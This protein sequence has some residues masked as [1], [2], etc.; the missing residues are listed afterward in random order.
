[1]TRDKRLFAR[2]LVHQKIIST[3]VTSA[4]SQPCYRFVHESR[5]WHALLSEGLS[6]T[7]WVIISPTYLSR[8]TEA[9]QKDFLFKL[10]ASKGCYG[11]S[12]ETIS[13]QHETRAYASR[14]SFETISSIRRALW[15]AVKVACLHFQ[16][17][18]RMKTSEF[19]SPTSATSPKLSCTKVNASKAT[20]K[21]Q[22]G[23]HIKP[24]ERNKI[25]L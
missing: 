16:L 25:L 7:R 12:V 4:R 2:R 10:F 15:W 17:D 1:M 23:T 19:L 5:L 6:R 9:I 24:G 22:F 13:K 21:L 20:K 14:V 3:W 11:V 8:T 18:K